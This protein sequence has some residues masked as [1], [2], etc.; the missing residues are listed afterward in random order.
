VMSSP[1]TCTRSTW[2][3]H[4]L[5]R[6]ASRVSTRIATIGGMSCRP[7]WRRVRFS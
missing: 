4:S 7:R 2:R 6:L 3:L 1:S 5:S